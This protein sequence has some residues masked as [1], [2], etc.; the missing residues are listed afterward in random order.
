MTKALPL[1]VI[2]VAIGYAIVTIGAASLVGARELVAQKENALAVAGQTAAGSVGLLIVTFTACAS[3]ASAIN[4]TLFSVSR[5][6]R[7]SA[8]GRLLPAICAKSNRRDS[9]YWS[10]ILIGAAAGL[11]AIRS[12]LE[13]LV[14]VASLA[15]LA[16]FWF[17][18]LLATLESR[19]RS[20][21]A[22]AGM[23][24]SLGS[25]VVVARSLVLGHPRAFALFLVACAVSIAAHFI[26][27][28]RR[29][30]HG[31]P[32]LA[33]DPD[34]QRKRRSGLKELKKDAPDSAPYRLKD[35]S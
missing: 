2:A 12:S 11:V 3:A 32:A 28:S 24:A 8:E 31:E 16:L 27:G 5:L 35:G 13:S 17:I 26:M 22:L 4:A 1:A 7:S 15:F 33:R 14:Q 23:V 18:N 20:W 9:P 25:A 30:A 29:K 10:V 19:G 21:V 34:V 6:A